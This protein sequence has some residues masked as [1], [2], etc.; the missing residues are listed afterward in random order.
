MYV[1]RLLQPLG[2]DSCFA[3]NFTKPG[4]L[5]FN[6]ATTGGCNCLLPSMIGRSQNKN[7]CQSTYLSTMAARLEATTFAHTLQFW[8]IRHHFSNSG[9]SIGRFL[10]HVFSQCSQCAQQPS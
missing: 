3:I 4:H 10:F 6:S 5:R 7:A 8:A 9:Y 1:F 2:F